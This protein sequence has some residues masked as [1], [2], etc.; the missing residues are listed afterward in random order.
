LPLIFR[1]VPE[2]QRLIRFSLGRY[3]GAPRGPG[4]V[5]TLPIV[6]Q[7]RVVDLREEVFEI[8]PQ[9]C[10]TKDNAPVTVDML[11]FMRVV[12]PDDSVINVQS[13]RAASRGMAITTLRSVVGDL[14]LDDVLA[15]RDHINNLMATRMDEVT[16]RWGVK[17]N[18]VEIKEILPPREIQEAMSRQMSAERHRRAV[19]IDSEGAREAAINIA[20]GSQ[21]AAILSA[22]GAKQAAIL[23]A[24]GDRQAAILNA[25]GFSLALQRIYESASRVDEKTMSLQYLDMMKT[26]ANG[27]ST[28][29][30][31]PMELTNFVQGFARNLAVASRPD[32]AG[33]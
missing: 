17:V 15:K 27:P 26:L 25:E 4:W 8:D 32:N 23:T 31:I 10:I 22:E 1:I 3:D 33:G 6:H 13:Y 7:V 20:G 30:V 19:V 5:W 16:E 21:Q 29:W 12:K 24:E 14:S 11:V 18:A 2:Y 28:K 9:T